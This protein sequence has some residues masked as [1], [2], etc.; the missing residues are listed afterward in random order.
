[1]AQATAT[2]I[3][4]HNGKKYRL[5]D[6]RD[7]GKQVY[8]DDDGFHRALEENNILQCRLGSIDPAREF[9]FKV[10]TGSRWA[11]A[12]TNSKPQSPL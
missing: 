6:H 12:F 10:D 4:E 9:P 5:A 8:V 3:Y 7:I 1:M 11:Y 2:Q